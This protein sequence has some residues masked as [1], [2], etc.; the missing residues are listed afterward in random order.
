MDDQTKLE[1]LI[2]ALENIAA[3]TDPD[4][5]PELESYDDTE[6]AFSNG[7]DCAWSEA[8]RIARE[9]LQAIQGEE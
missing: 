9:A 8:S 5:E 2:A 6:S 7:V 1:V 3:H 4:N